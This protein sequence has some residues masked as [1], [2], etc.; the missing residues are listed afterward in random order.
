MAVSPQRRNAIRSRRMICEALV[1]LLCEKEIDNITVT[2]LVERADLN[3]STFYSHYNNMMDV[4]EEME[5]L[6][7]EQLAESLRNRRLQAVSPELVAAALARLM[8]SPG[9][10]SH[11]WLSSPVLVRMLQRVADRFLELCLQEASSVQ[12]QR[13][14]FALSLR[15]A[16]YGTVH[17]MLARLEGKQFTDITPEQLSD[18]LVRLYSRL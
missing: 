14:G 2:E 8:L 16:A 9:A 1:A 10:T 5:Q 7:L 4:L 13:P 3:R 17:V 6:A 11:K 12:L 15:L 18:E